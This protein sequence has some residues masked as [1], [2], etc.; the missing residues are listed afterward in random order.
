MSTASADTLTPREHEILSELPGGATYN[1]IARRLGLSKHTV[2][3][4]IRRIRLKTGAM[5]RTEMVVL[6]LELRDSSR[7]E[8]SGVPARM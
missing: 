4:Y 8:P 3:T 7:S 2:D 1:A 5:N 6:A